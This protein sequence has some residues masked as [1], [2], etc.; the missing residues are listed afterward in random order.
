MCFI[1]RKEGAFAIWKYEEL[2][3]CFEDDKI[4]ELFCD[5]Y[6]V[7]KEGNVDAQYDLHGDL[8]NTVY[9]IPW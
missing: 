1:D 6:S 7:K 5:F 3:A 2:K 4:L 9:I 8:T